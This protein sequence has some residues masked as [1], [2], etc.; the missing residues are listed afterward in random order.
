[1]HR[2]R[3]ISAALCMS[4]GLLAQAAR[5]QSTALKDQIALDEQKLAEASAGHDKKDK[6][7]LLNRLA[8]LY[9][10]SGDT[11]KAL[12]YCNQSLAL[13][14]S[15]RFHTGQALTK[16]IMARIY[17]DTGDEKKALDILTE[18]LPFWQSGHNRRRAALFHE[19]LYFLLGKAST[20]NNLGMV[21]N[22]LGEKEKALEY[23]N[24]ALQ[25]A[26]A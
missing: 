25:K 18:L 21:Y 12:D 17:T 26:A 22:N 10:Q 11:K 3:I 7:I 19:S 4:L 24:Q 14:K 20:L 16:D 23:F 9:R 6:V 1:M 15:A 2:L 13:E 5:G 8:T